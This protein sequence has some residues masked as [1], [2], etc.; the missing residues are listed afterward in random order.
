M[1]RKPSEEEIDELVAAQADEDSAWE[2]PIRVRRDKPI[3]FV[4]PAELVARAGFF[5]KLHGESGPDVWLTRIIRERLDM[6]ETAFAGIKREL[7]EKQRVSENSAMRTSS[8]T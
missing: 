2:E 5:A 1:T 3:S 4:I 7:K 8:H 6:E